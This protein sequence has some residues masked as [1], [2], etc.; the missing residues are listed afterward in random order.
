[1]QKAYSEGKART[2]PIPACST[3][4]DS[5]PANI[6]YSKPLIVL[7]DELSVSAADIFAAMMQDNARGPIV[8][9]RTAGWGGAIDVSQTGTYSEASSS[10]TKTL[11]VRKSPVATEGYPTSSYI[12]NA[13][14]T[15]DIRLEAMTKENL[16]TR[17]KAYVDGFTQIIVDRIKAVR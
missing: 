9:T 3:G 15:P 7:A 17:G 11:V 13:G 5:S 14:V 10:Y 6:V 1:M 8:G 16:L 4:F 12:E 2:T